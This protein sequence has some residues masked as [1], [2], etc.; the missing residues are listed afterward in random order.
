MTYPTIQS[1]LVES[2]KF[3]G[4]LEDIA[5]FLKANCVEAMN[6]LGN[7]H[8]YRGFRGNNRPDVFIYTVRENRTPL[9]M[10]ASRTQMFNDRIADVGLVA[11]RTNSA[12]CTG[13]Y[14]T[15][16]QFDSDVD[17]SDGFPHLVFPIGPFN[18][19]WFPDVEDGNWSNI[20]IIGK[21]EQLSPEDRERLRHP[22]ER[23][24]VVDKLYAMALADIE[25]RGDDGSLK[26]A[27][28]SGNEI[29]VKP[30]S[31]KLFCIRA[32]IFDQLQDLL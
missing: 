21:I 19:T 10:S 18:Y 3:E 4:S 27:I 24:E 32:H 5:R 6:A 23:A 11:H 28:R 16:S 25:V 14:D 15:A 22:Q 1:L 13:N 7:A 26:E 12:M 31:G 2:N 29:M 20:P 9:M 8:M 30:V 17:E